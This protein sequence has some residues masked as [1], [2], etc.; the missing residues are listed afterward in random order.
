MEF[1]K[2]RS[3]AILVFFAVVILA[4]F[5]AANR[6]LSSKVQEINDLF[7]DGV[8]DPYLGYR[9]P[10]IRRQLEVRSNASNNLLS[11]GLKF[12]EAK[13]ETEALS[14]ART[15][16]INGISNSAGAGKLYDINQEL[17][18]A[19]KALYERLR[20]LPLNNDQR[21]TVDDSLKD[22][23][24]SAKKIQESGYNEAVRAFNRE[25]LSVFPTNFLMKIVFVDPPEL[26]E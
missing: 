22:W 2:K 19:Y 24:G 8:Y 6:S 11:V 10:S 13:A 9:R 7:S 23:E 14:E 20:T 16:L 5:F 1:F 26:F 15:R 18:S 3:G 4:S 12:P 25:V 21:K 17:D